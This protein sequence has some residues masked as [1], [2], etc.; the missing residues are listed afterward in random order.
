MRVKR[1]FFLSL[2]SLLIWISLIPITAVVAQQEESPSVQASD[3]FVISLRVELV[4][5]DV[6]VQN[7][8]GGF[9]SNLTQDNFQIFENGQPQELKV[10]QKGD[11]PVTAGLVMDSSGSMRMIK[12]QVVA[13]GMAF[14]ESMNPQDEI[15]VVNFN[16]TPRFSLPNGQCFSNKPEELQTAL[17]RV[18][19]AGRTAL[20]DSLVLSLEH[21]KRGKNDKKALL[22]ISDG[23]DNASR[24]RF[25]EALDLVEK[26]RVM[27]YSIAI[28][29]P[30]NRER[31]PK[32]LKR[33]SRS[34]GGEFFS[35]A[36][37]TEVTTICSQVARDIRNQYTLGYRSSNPAQDGTFRA[38]KVIVNAPGSSKFH[39]RTREGYVAAKES[40]SNNRSAHI[41]P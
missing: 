11:V 17:N 3:P 8:D 22:V 5:L 35:P 19:P 33:L 37:I 6:T 38:I 21:L 39:V 18:F 23:G 40:D 26:S 36:S 28:F 14:V 24:R 15:F 34:S 2:F 30:I 1:L 27:L 12:R 10:F 29:D 4:V 16:E 25:S 13:A 41:N 32:V 9:I 20:Y 31:N 7:K